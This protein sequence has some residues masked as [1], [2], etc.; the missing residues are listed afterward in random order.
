MELKVDIPESVFQAIE[1]HE[2]DVAAAVKE[3]ALVELFRQSRLSH[4]ELAIGLGISRAEVDAVLTRHNVTED[5]PTLQEIE[6]QLAHMR[7]L[8]G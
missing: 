8:A 6:S 2:R 5:L 4:G 3:A 7:K 1:H